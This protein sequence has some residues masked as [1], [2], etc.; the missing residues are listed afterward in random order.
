MLSR[1]DFHA[2]FQSPGPVILPV[3]HVLDGARTQENI[4]RV[5]SAGLNGCFLI[6][7]DFEKEALIPILREMRAA[8]PTLW[9]GVNFLANTG[10]AAFPIL[11]DLAR[12]GCHID[13]YWADDAC[14][15]EEGDNAHAAEIARIREESGWSGM[16]FGG[17]AFKKQRDVAPNRYADAA[18]HAA[19]YM[20]VITTS[21]VAT[22]HE[23]DPS[24]IAA[25][26]K[27][28]GDRPLALASGIT[29]ENAVAYGDV[30]CFMVATG[31]NEPG[32]FY[33]IDPDRLKALID[34]CKQLA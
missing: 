14:I 7:H 12:S 18:G 16:Y 32:N 2:L 34:A 8:F 15:N 20:D 30:D 10:A 25:F 3:I 23:A 9:V 29:P 22:G 19:P 11:G 26:R 24:K 17:T 13:A 4:E 5:V 21:G 31:I 6:N 28:I 27:G 1:S 33:D